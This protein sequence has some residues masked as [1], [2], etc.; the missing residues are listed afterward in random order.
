[1]TTLMRSKWWWL[2]T[3]RDRESLQPV[4]AWQPRLSSIRL[5]GRTEA[6]STPRSYTSWKGKLSV[7][8]TRF[9][10]IM[11]NGR[12]EVCVCISNALRVVYLISP[13]C[14]FIRKP[15]LYI[16]RKKKNKKFILQTTCS[17]RIYVKFVRIYA[18][19]RRT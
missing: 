17:T 14:T 3:E 19:F 5:C 15:V 18:T 2:G 13:T 1:M 11:R 12:D 8:L 10:R 16:I 9:D 7:L 4:S 6:R